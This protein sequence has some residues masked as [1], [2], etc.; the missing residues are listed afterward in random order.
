MNGIII[1]GELHELVDSG[2]YEAQCG[3]CSMKDLCC[4]YNKADILIDLTCYMHNRQQ[5][6]EYKTMFY[7]VN[8]GKVKIEK[9]E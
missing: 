3:M 6:D 7:F 9:E 2:K 1:N 5:G 8:R 4:K